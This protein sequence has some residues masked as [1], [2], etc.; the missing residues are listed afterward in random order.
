MRI[1]LHHKMSQN[2]YFSHKLLILDE[3]T[4]AVDLNT[5]TLMQQMIR[6]HFE[7]LSIVTISNRLN[8][9]IDYDLL[10]CC[11]VIFLC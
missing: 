8:T 7:G 2:Q 9:I 6:Q 10:V 3:A 11:C 4:S 1:L 5:D